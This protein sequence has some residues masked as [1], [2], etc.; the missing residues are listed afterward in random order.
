MSEP[1]I[2]LNSYCSTCE[3][4]VHEAE[5]MLNDIDVDN[6]KRQFNRI[7]QWVFNAELRR[8]CHM[9][10]LLL[11]TIP[12]RS[13]IENL[14]D[15]RKM[16]TSYQLSLNQGSSLFHKVVTITI[17]S[18]NFEPFAESHV[19]FCEGLFS[20]Y[21]PSI[22][23]VLTTMVDGKR[24]DFKEQIHTMTWSS[25]TVYQ[26]REWLKS[27]AES[28]PQ[29]TGSRSKLDNPNRR[30][31]PSRL[32]DTGPPLLHG[33]DISTADMDSLS[34]ESNSYLHLC[35]TESFPTDTKY[36]TLSHRWSNP[37]AV[38]LNNATAEQFRSSIPISEMLKPEAATLKQAVHVTRCLG[39]RYLWID[40]LCINQEEEQDK[41]HE[42]SL[43]GEI[44]AGSELNLAATA[45]SS[46]SDGLFHV[47]N[48]MEVEPFRKRVR[49][50]GD[51]DWIRG[52]TIVY[53]ANF[54]GQVDTAPLNRRGWV[55]QER[56]LAHRVLHFARDQVYWTCSSLLA[57][58]VMPYG[59]PALKILFGEEIRRWHL[60]IPLGQIS[61][62]NYR[63]TWAKL[64]ESYSIT[65]VT[66]PQD[67][68]MAISAISR[69]MCKIRNLSPRDYLAGLWRQDLPA[70]LLWVVR[71][72]W[73]TKPELL[74]YI[75]PSWSWASLLTTGVYW[76][77][78]RL[79]NI[80]ADLVDVSVSLKTTDPYGELT[81]GYVRLRGPMCKLNRRISP[82][83]GAVELDLLGTY[84]PRNIITTYW[85]YVKLA[86]ECSSIDDRRQH[87]QD[88]IT[89]PQLYLFLISVDEYF[90]KLSGLILQPIDEVKGRYRRLGCFQIRGTLDF[91]SIAA[92][93]DGEFISFKKPNM[94]VIDII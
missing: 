12:H 87:C 14:V 42:I 49:L 43:M 28:H 66:F 77:L 45:A 64:I 56:L 93:E 92:L 23:S 50:H 72:P 32:L 54:D 47:R 10:A 39:F 21:V 62:R 44:Y 6:A 26:V 46:G 88:I 4:I 17:L 82:L 84:H 60:E 41:Q 67:K 34:L 25:H 76:G 30:P 29:C 57:A 15:D 74:P 40:A 9:C 58:E 83:T 24:K 86:E 94:Y 16:E 3:N 36:L 91:F 53:T 20:L 65:S 89:P 13:L 1:K 71:N 35:D 8:S 7:D 38:T 2:N 11:R 81:S 85:D 33:E 78:S 31:L 27:C 51:T 61:F 63:G 59:N 55:F 5:C 37:P 48:P 73:R 80:V 69:K 70:Q 18:E 90:E 22:S 75:A 19:I 68:L 79:G 52:D